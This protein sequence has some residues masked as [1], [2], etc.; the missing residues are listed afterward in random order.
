MESVDKLRKLGKTFAHACR[1]YGPREQI[2]DIADAIEAEVA[3]RYMKLPVDGDGIPVHVG[4]V[5]YGAGGESYEADA[6]DKEGMLY[7]D[8][9][10]GRSEYEYKGTSGL[11][12]RRPPTVEGVLEKALNEAAMLDRKEGY[13]Q[14]AADVTNIVDKYVNK[15]RLAEGGDAS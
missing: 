13:W 10:D 5:L 6:V 14:S 11:R 7:F 3:E 4:D 12:H 8:R 1:G 9:E 15:L 2:E